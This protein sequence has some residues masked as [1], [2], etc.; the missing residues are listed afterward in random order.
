MLDMGFEPQI[1]KILQHMGQQRHNMFFTAT[2]P[3]DVRQLASTMLWQPFRVMIGKRD[4]LKANQDVTQQVRI[5]DQ[6]GKQNAIKELLQEAGLMDPNSSG[7][8]LVFASTKRM[9]EELSQQLYR[10]G[11][12]CAAI[13]GD[14]EQRE[15]DHALNGLK[16]GRI[17]VLCATDVAARGL[18]IKGVGLVV[19]YDVANNTEDYVHRIGRTGRAGAKGY[20]VTFLTRAD[21]WKA[22]GMIKVMESTNQEVTPELRALA[23]GGGGG[24]ERSRYGG[25][26]GKGGGG[27]SGP[28]KWC[29]MGDCWSHKGGGS[30]GKGGKGGK[31]GGG[32]DGHIGLGP[33]TGLVNRD[34]KGSKGGGGKGGGWG[35]GGGDASSCMWCAKGECWTHKGAGKG[36]RSRSPRR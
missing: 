25:G 29:A 35:G 28:C 24:G 20:A 22:S 16:A 30:G 1:R 26:G 11:I 7:K 17:R 27:G 13:H 4:Q 21:G 9:C 14:K 3:R 32:G 33:C 23:S 12:H 8:A 6:R 34:G 10:E 36:G 18:D 2:W 5:V 15:R 19:N 31:G